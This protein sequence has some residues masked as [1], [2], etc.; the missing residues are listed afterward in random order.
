MPFRQHNDGSQRLQYV[1]TQ[2]ARSSD[3]RFVRGDARR[4]V[5]VAFCWLS[6]GQGADIAVIADKPDGVVTPTYAPLTYTN[7]VL[8]RCYM[9]RPHLRHPQRALRQNVKLTKM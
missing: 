3:R 7:T 4:L 1:R 6:Y 9:F 2:T 8:H 5:H